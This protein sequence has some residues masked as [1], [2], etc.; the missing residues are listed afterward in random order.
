MDVSGLA[1][2]DYIVEVTLNRSGALLGKERI[3]W[4]KSGDPEWLGNDI[5]VIRKV[6]PPWTPVK[7]KGKSIEVWGR[8]HS[9]VHSLLPAAMTVL[10]E[11]ILSGPMRLIIKTA[12]ETIDTAAVNTPRIAIDRAGIRAT[13][14][15][16]AVGKSLV[17][18]VEGE[19][20]FDGFGYFTFTLKP[21]DET[22]PVSVQSIV[23]EV[24]FK[25]K[26]AELYDDSSY[27]LFGTQSGRIPSE[28]LELAGTD[29]IR[30]GDTSR[31]VQFYPV[32]GKL[33]KRAAAKPLSFAPT[34]DAMTMR[35]VVSEGVTIACPMTNA[36][37]IIGTPVKPS[38]AK[39]IRMTGHATGPGA[40]PDL[41]KK[42]YSGAMYWFSTWTNF[43]GGSGDESA[44]FNYSPQWCQEFAKSLKGDWE[45][46]RQYWLLKIQPSLITVRSPEY[47]L[48]W[49]EWGGQYYDCLGEYDR[50]L[51]AYRGAEKRPPG[52]WTEVDW[53]KRSWQDFYFYSMDKAL[54]AFAKEGVRVG[55]YVDCTQHGGD[56]RP[57]R[58]WMQRLYE[59]VRKYSPEGLIVVHVS[60][61]RRMAVWGMADIV[62]E[63]EQYSS[64][65]LAYIAN[66]PDLTLNDCYPTVLPL[67]R[68]RAT[69]AATLW[70]PQEVFLSQFWT[71]PR[72]QEDV[73]RKEKG[74]PGPSYYKRMR[75]ITG[76][77]LLHD[78]PFW[79]EF[80]ACGVKEDPWVKRARWGYDDTVMF[81]PY[82][83]SRGMLEVEAP[84]KTNVV[85]SAWLRPD[86]NLMAI[87]FNNATNAVAVRLK[88]NARM[89]PVPLKAFT[90]AVDIT[91]P[92]A[93]FNPD[94][95]KPDTYESKE[96][97]L[98]LDMRPR[99]FRLLVFEQ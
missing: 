80:Y 97:V 18:E 75:Y 99:D 64:N 7:K 52:D 95:T 83:D 57:Y 90:R 6:P 30:V 25:K 15:G 47:A 85:A 76:L 58:Q 2:G 40:N 42:G 66:K 63:G 10:D 34:A 60:G 87:V 51:S 39:R 44:Y 92:V 82:W 36:I 35:Y 46:S 55:V 32:F 96:G 91:S 45:Q 72:Q 50:D 12:N 20:E 73:R 70:G 17:V 53:S 59:V 78:T 93:A 49:K 26:Y 94:A 3:K 88:V 28:G 67:D 24:P 14:K 1:T 33:G 41:N 61:D 68:M 22:K 19:L 84:D 89:F 8:S 16:R 86:G 11:D 65:W 37:G 81:I 56:P 38:D 69:Y 29:T 13:I 31:G 23:F 21:V 4:F 5:G 43:R 62:V 54:S 98:E 48:F 74:D 27:D 79:G 77:M 9:F 71:D